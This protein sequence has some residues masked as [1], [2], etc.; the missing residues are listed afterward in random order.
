MRYLG[1]AL[2]AEG[3][4]DYRFLSPVLQRLCEDLCLTHSRQQV[5]I[6]EVSGIDAPHTARGEARE[7][8]IMAAATGAAGSWNI[9]FIHSDGAG[10]PHA[11]LENLVEPAMRRLRK[12]FLPKAQA[13]PVIPVRETESWLL[14]DGDALREVFGT[15]MTD[16]EL[17][18]PVGGAAVEAV[19]DPKQALKSAFAATKLSPRRARAGTAAL[20]NPL[21]E[22]IGLSRLRE[23]ASFQSLESTLSAALT[24]L[25]IFD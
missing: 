15:R 21:G 5:E 1:L 12:G 4:T 18:L 7:E 9:L 10:D 2:F 14:S 25:G 6:S 17:G 22:R 3:K 13:V 23:L 20:L 11:A 19:L 8:R 16:F 24:D